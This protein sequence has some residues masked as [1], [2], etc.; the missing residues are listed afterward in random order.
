MP[1]TTKT[2]SQH[3]QH[4]PSTYK[5]GRSHDE[6]GFTHSNGR[7]NP[8]REKGPFQF[9]ARSFTGNKKLCSSK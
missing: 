4:H 6:D 2:E 7:L 9:S 3:P 1:R 5:G 8:I